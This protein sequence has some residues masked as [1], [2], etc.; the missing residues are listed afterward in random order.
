MVIDVD[1]ADCMAL[2]RLLTSRRGE[3]LESLRCRD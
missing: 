1:D 3:Y 2:I